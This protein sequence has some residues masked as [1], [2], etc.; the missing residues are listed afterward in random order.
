MLF[1]KPYILYQ[2]NQSMLSR[3]L[4]SRLAFLCNKVKSK[5]FNTELGHRGVH[6]KALVNAAKIAPHKPQILVQGFAQ[7]GI[8]ALVD[9]ATGYQ[10]IRD[11]QALQEILDRFLR[12]EL[13]AWANT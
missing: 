11:R 4:L 13:A 8:V 2:K 7:V 6:A 3:N 10:A 9:E 12:K 1:F 5:C